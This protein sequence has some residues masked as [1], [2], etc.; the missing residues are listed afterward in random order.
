MKPIDVKS[1]L[2]VVQKRI[3]Q[4]CT[5]AGR[6]PQEV[7]LIAVTKTVDPGTIELANSLGIRHFGESRIQDAEDKIKALTHLQPRP[8]WH[9]IGHL[10]SNKVK[11]ALELFDII[12][13]IDS[14]ALAESI[15]KRAQK[16]RPILLQVNV[17][18]EKT[19]SGL[20]LIET[21]P[22]FEAI[23]KL[24][25][26]KIQ[27]LMTIAPLVENP[28]EV[29]LIFRKLKEL[30]D[31]LH[32]EHLSMGMTDDFEVAIEEGATMIRIGRGIFGERK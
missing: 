10:Q 3:V 8:M 29:R 30:K 6:S 21:E 15:S 14:V 32:L 25:N 9:M 27:G 31:Y 2:E 19:K 13:T 23:A 18:G 20:S 22:T 16:M 11:P 26:L 24:P 17:S 5:R 1:N 4:A 7:T 12:Q 28:D